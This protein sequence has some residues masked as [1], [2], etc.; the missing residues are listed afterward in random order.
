MI[1][2]RLMLAVTGLELVPIYVVDRV[3]R[4]ARAFEAQVD[5]FHC[6][7]EPQAAQAQAVRG[8]AANLIAAR[9]E[10]RRRRLER[11]ADILRDQGVTVSPSV[12]WDYPIY[13]GIIRQALRH[14]PDL[15]IVPAL[16]LE[17]AHRALVYRELRLIEA[18]PCAV[19]FV[20]TREIYSKGCIVAAVEPE[21]AREADGDLDELAIGAAKTLA[22]AL[23]DVPVH[24]YHAEPPAQHA[25]P[26]PEGVRAEAQ[27]RRLA[28]LHEIGAQQVQVECGVP[29]ELLPRYVRQ[30]RAQSLVI[31]VPSGPSARRHGSEQLTERLVDALE[32]DLLVVKSRYAHAGVGTE[33]SPAVLPQ[34][35]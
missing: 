35:L 21:H 19:L 3:G 2:R 14:K 8:G 4:L 11:L 9:V 20:K 17:E 1:W 16:A 5:L 22:G 31:G 32:C 26:N 27:V 23:A 12:R 10:E 18:A 30:A 13:E 15:L 25:G 28:E 34:S 7:Y 33:P 29:E 6:L 24:L